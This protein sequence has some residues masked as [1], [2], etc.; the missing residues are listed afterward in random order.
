MD[1]YSITNHLGGGRVG[2]S[3]QAG[4]INGDVNVHTPPPPALPVPRQLPAVSAAFVDR[5][6]ELADAG[7]WLA[8][9]QQ[10]ALQLL[11]LHGPGGVGK[12][13]FATRLLHHVGDRFPG[14][15][16]FADLHGHLPHG[17]PPVPTAQIL[18]SL[19]RAV[20]Q[21]PLPADTGELSSWWRSLTATREPM[22]F[23]LDN[24]ADAEQVRDLLPGGTGHLVAITARRPEP[25]AGLVGDGAV[26]L[27]LAPLD[28]QTA[29]ELVLRHLKHHPARGDRRAAERLA[30]QCNGIPLA[31]GLAAARLILQSHRQ[32]PSLTASPTA[33][34]SDGDGDGDGEIGQ[35]RSRPPTT[36]GV[37]MTSADRAYGRLDP[38]P[39]Q[40]YRRLGSM[41]TLDTDPRMTAAACNLPL[42]QSDIA[43]KHLAE[44]GLLEDRGAHPDRG[45]VYRFHDE[46]RDHARRLSRQRDGAAVLARTRRR[47]L[48]W[49]LTVSTA[50]ERQLTSHHRT[51]DVG[52]DY[53]YPPAPDTLPQLTDPTSALEWLEAQHHNFMAI[54]RAAAAENPRQAVIYQMV[55][56]W[57]P[58]WHHRQNYALWAEAHQL[59]AEAARLSGN[60]LAHR[61]ILNTWGIGERGAARYD[62]AIDLF[63]QVLQM[64]RDAGDNHS[65]SQAE[66]ELGVAHHSAGHPDEALVFLRESL[67]LRQAIGYSRGVALT[68]IVLG[69]V[70]LDLGEAERAVTALSEAR[71]DLRE[72]GEIFEAARALAFLGHTRAQQHD[73]TT[74]EEHLH[75]ARD[76]VIQSGAHPRWLARIAEMLGQCAADQGRRDIAH[77]HFQQALASFELINP[78][79]A[80]RIRDRLTNLEAAPGDPTTASQPPVD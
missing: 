13:S 9:Q 3:V 80:Q 71:S 63:S 77:D 5:E 43:L 36:T 74:A 31:L 50:I 16:F 40:V 57:W 62:E 78:R 17:D 49:L 23:L 72:L 30:H 75:Q 41:T 44:T 29:V 14:G 32:H 35:A 73:F 24:A 54:I 28:G 19:T 64:A 51:D 70:Y 45:R 8:D 39:A 42:H 68:R 61:E 27:P 59:A 66:H 11:V 52:R 10:D 12:T 25:L 67:Q 58:W 21:G 4:S 33:P 47:T 65:V 56:A 22:A 18:G 79:D 76:E 7:R 69:Q 46:L 60:L 20:W 1:R 2:A 34:D 55:H 37:I 26:M 53:R 48:D 15:H 38:Q 6:A